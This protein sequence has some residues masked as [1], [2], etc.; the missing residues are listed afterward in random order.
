MSSKGAHP[1][2]RKITTEALRRMKQKGKR[3]AA[4]TAYDALMAEILDKAGVMSSWSETALAPWS[5]AWTP[6]YPSPWT[7]WSTTP[8]W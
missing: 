7:R 3:I 2:K 6:R 8:A 1:K 5:R 4:L